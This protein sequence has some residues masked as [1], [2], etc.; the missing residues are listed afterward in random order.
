[1]AK[2]SQDVYKFSG[3]ENFLEGIDKLDALSI[4]RLTDLYKKRK[5][6]FIV[7]NSI[8]HCETQSELFIARSLELIE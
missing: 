2:A 4:N 8:H 6:K 1:M 7:F 5:D 3:I